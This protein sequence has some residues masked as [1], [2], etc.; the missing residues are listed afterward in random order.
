MRTKIGER[1]EKKLSKIDLLSTLAQ[2][3]AAP[4]ARPG[5]WRQRTTGTQGAGQAKL[6]PIVVFP[7]PP[8]QCLRNRPPQLPAHGK[9]VA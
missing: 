4:K 5:H 9:G 2:G 7:L 6:Q 3:A 8:K 1:R